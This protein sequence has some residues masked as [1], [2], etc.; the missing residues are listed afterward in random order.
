MPRLIVDEA[1]GVERADVR[2][3]DVLV[4]AEHQPQMR[5]GGERRGL[6][7]ADD[8]DVDAFV[9]ASNSRANTSWR[10]AVRVGRAESSSP[11]E[12]QRED[13]KKNGISDRFELCL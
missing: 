3:R 5:I 9:S 1:L 12:I 10:G 2:E 6:A 13:V 7:V 11:A 4:P 8:A